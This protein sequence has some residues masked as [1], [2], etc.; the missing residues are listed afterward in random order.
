MNRFFIIIALLVMGCIGSIAA[1]IVL[2]KPD[3]APPRHK[4]YES[5]TCGT[6]RCAF[7]NCTTEDTP[8][9]IYADLLEVYGH[10]ETD[11]TDD[12]DGR[13]VV[14]AGTLETG[15]YSTRAACEAAVKRI[16][17][18]ETEK[19]TEINKYR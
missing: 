13:V 5:A 17:E 1:V 18:L 19:I 2:E 14:R 7:M 8:G 4:W 3:P 9:Q 15:F 11:L 6:E 16:H 12:G 10:E